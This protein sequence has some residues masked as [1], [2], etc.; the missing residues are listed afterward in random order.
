M[1]HQ[2][3]HS[4]L[5]SLPWYRPSQEQHG[6]HRKCLLYLRRTGQGLRTCQDGRTAE[7]CQVH[8]HRVLHIWHVLRA[9]DGRDKRVHG[10]SDLQYPF[11]IGD[12]QIH[13]VS[14]ET[15]GW[16]PSDEHGGSKGPS[17]RWGGRVGTCLGHL[18]TVHTLSVLR[19]R[20]CSACWLTAAEHITP[21]LSAANNNIHL[22]YSWILRFDQ[23]LVRKASHNCGIH[24]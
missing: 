9:V 6:L 22:F 21:Q 24:F 5:F 3:S 17:A 2:L 13:C 4:P 8:H 11:R 1:D 15:S 10:Q 16:R 12:L 14:P 7:A 18:S 19:L 23:S 20:G